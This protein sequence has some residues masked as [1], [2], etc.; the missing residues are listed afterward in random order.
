M[1][2][3][4]S[5]FQPGDNSFKPGLHYPSREL[6]CSIVEICEG[7]I[8]AKLDVQ[9]RKFATSPQH[10]GVT[11]QEVDVFLQRWIPILDKIFFFGLVQKVLRKV[12]VT[13]RTHCW[14]S[15]SKQFVGYYA[16]VKICIGMLTFERCQIHETQR[17]GWVGL[18]TLVHEMLHAFLQ[19]YG[20]SCSGPEGCR[21]TWRQHHS[22]DFF[23][24]LSAI[25]RA[26]KRDLPV[27]V[28]LTIEVDV[29]AEMDKGMLIPEEYITRWG[30]DEMQ[31]LCYLELLN[32]NRAKTSW[33]GPTGKTVSK[34]KLLQNWPNSNKKGCSTSQA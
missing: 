2:E 25:N 31:L 32:P 17:R 24:A 20:C 9:E 16:N 22:L 21:Q 1:Y 18:G 28:E 7:D 19:L 33:K 27:D 30:L 29:A 13:T 26:I 6:S 4:H 11:R 14:W 8:L 15:P 34:A 23:E 12:K 10:C 3:K 5:R